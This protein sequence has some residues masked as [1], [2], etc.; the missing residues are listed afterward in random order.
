MIVV[1]DTSALIGLATCSSLDVLTDLY[2][3]V[4]V[5]QAVYREV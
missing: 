1:A 5:P 4:F 3:D 2:K